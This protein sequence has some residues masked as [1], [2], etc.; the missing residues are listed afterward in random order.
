MPASPADAA[1]VYLVG[2]G[3]GDP[4]LLTLKA[5]RLLDE[6]DVVVYDRLVS[7]EIMALL[8][9]GTPRISV[10]K[11]P[12]CHPV[13]QSDINRLLVSLARDGR[14]VVRLKG[15]DPFLFGRGS[16]EAAH[17]HDHG[18]RYEVVPGVTSA[19][20]CAA[21]VGLPLTHRG[22]ASGVRFLTGHCRNDIDLDLDWRGLSDPDTT[23]VLY[24]GMANLPQIAVR[25]IA[26]GLPD[27]TPVAAVCN[28]TRPDQRHAISTLGEVASVAAAA[29]FD[30][31]V[32]FIIGRVVELAAALGIAGD[33]TILAPAARTLRTA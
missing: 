12:K 11:Q 3:P 17:L 33:E 4:E 6:A 7:D 29:R 24:M 1:V 31:P 18:I 32:L 21:A 13:P 20:G 8:P 26:H 22:L 30:G 15:G 5:R 23:L 10:G 27:T 16:E 9:A 19:S 2:A 25:L 28:G 14:K